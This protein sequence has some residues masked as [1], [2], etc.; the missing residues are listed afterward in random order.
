ME[1]LVELRAKF[2]TLTADKKVGDFSFETG[3]VPLLWGLAEA[4]ERL[5]LNCRQEFSIWQV[6]EK[7]GRLS[8]HGAAGPEISRLTEE[9]EFTSTHICAVCGRPGNLVTRGW[10]RVLCT[11][12]QNQ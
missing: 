5:D 9:V 11:A 7:F 3:W 4:I 6:K 2:A 8:I 1:S 10:Y 12:H